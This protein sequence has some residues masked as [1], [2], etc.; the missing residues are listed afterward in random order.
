[1][2][3][4]IVVVIILV[5]VLLPKGAEFFTVASSYGVGEYCFYI[6][7]EVDEEHF[8]RV[9]KNGSDTIGYCSLINAPEVKKQYRGSINGESFTLTG[10][11]LTVGEIVTKLDARVVSEGEVNGIYTVYLYTGRLNVNSIDLFGDKVNVQIALNGNKVT[12]G[13]PIILGSY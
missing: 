7:G 11:K 10:T 9:D 8:Q 5:L 12:V 1:M 4:Y 6:S 3:R 13:Y 2:K